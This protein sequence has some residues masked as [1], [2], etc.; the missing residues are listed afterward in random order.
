[1][2]CDKVVCER[3]CVTG[4]RRRRREATGIQNQKLDDGWPESVEEQ[5]LFLL[6]WRHHIRNYILRQNSRSARQ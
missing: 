2:V 6:V 5:G 3:W 4:G 1:M